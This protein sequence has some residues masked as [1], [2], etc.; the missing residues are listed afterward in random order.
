MEYK[1]HVTNLSCLKGGNIS[2]GFQVTGNNDINSA[3]GSSVVD[4]E[5]MYRA[6]IHCVVCLGGRGVGVGKPVF[7]GQSLRE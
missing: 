1:R 2:N 5:F 3:T 7:S 6:V 4:L